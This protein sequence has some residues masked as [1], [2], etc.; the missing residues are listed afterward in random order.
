MKRSK[1]YGQLTGLTKKRYDEKISII[2][3]LDPYILGTGFTN[4]WA[5]FP[6]ITSD[7]VCH[8]LVHTVS[9]YS[10]EE[11]LAEKAKCGVNF[12][13]SDKIGN[14]RVR[15]LGGYYLIRAKVRRVVGYGTHS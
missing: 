6:E 12:A 2:R 14:C 9:Y 5:K 8:Y 3:D 15:K 1:Y 4:D 11:F 13:A 7:M 10:F